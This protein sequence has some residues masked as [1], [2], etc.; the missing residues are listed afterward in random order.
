MRRPVR[1]A[2]D[3]SDERSVVS[4]A[5]LKRPR[6]RWTLRF[7]QVALFGGLLVTGLLPILWL[8]KAALSTTQDLISKPFGW[9][10]SGIQWQ[11]IPDAWEQIRVGLY[12][13]NTAIVAAGSVVAT[14]IVTV[15]LA[16]VIAI[17]RPRWA[18][19]LSGAILA[20]IFIPGV[21][22]LVPLYLT[23]LD[24]PIVG[25]SL[26]NTFWAVWLPTAANAFNVLVVKRFFD[27]I[28]REM[29]EA[30]TLDGAGP[31]RLLF[32]IVLPHSRPIIGVVAIF[33]VVGAWKDFL[34]PK[35]VLQT[36]ELQ[37]ISVA[38][39]R[40]SASAELSL[41]MAGM[42]LAIIIPLALFL[43]FQKQILRGVSL[44]GGTKG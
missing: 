13:G 39:P 41:Q 37:P 44:A 28:P 11:N 8:M 40:V 2:R 5:D 34:W 17:L 27:E 9:F 35:L 38:L 21:M 26:V 18:P 12:L 15:T 16:F 33:T 10:P 14:L 20:T 19:L 22:S 31:I 25:V 42:F 24:L 43:V 29:I 3:L 4:P 32:A 30:A 36:P 1:R 6:V 7:G 23:V